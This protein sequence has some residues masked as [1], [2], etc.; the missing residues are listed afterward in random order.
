MSLSFF[1]QTGQSVVIL[2]YMKKRCDLHSHSTFSDGSLTPAELVKLAE[3]RGISALALTD[4]NTSKGLSELMEAGRH[5]SVITVPGC[6]FTTEWNKIEIHIVGLFFREKYWQEIED[7]L[8]LTHIAKVN[9]NHKLI[10][11]LNKA[12]YDISAEEA[13]ALTDGE[14]NRAHIASVLMAKGYVE[15]V[16]EAFD[17]LLKPEKGFYVPPRRITSAATIRFIKTFGAVA[18]MAHGLVNLTPEQMR[19]FLPEAKK[20][21]LDAIE[22]RYTDYDEEMTK[23]AVSLAEEFGLRQSGGS[24]FHGQTKPNIS[25]GTGT[26]S[27]FVPYEF[28]EDLRSRADYDD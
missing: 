10:Q 12:G 8:E 28:Y 7:F 27:L 14:F 23:T 2:G 26:G 5:S 22:T 19:K 18:V 15:S 24:D 16:S 4:H 21:G 25:L 3:E 17:K 9:S 1:T 13:A 11:N 6:E 20:A